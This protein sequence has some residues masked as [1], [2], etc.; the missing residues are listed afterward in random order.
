MPQ[1]QRLLSYASVEG[2]TR[3]SNYIIYEIMKL[4]LNFQEMQLLI[5]PQT[6]TMHLGMDKLFHNNG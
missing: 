2:R 6:S 5:H 4:S 1:S 3:M